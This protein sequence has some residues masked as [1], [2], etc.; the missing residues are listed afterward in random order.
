[1]IRY[2]VIVRWAAAWFRDGRAEGNAVL[3]ST[4]SSSR[5]KIYRATHRLPNKLVFNRTRYNVAGSTSTSC[6]FMNASVRAGYVL[7]SR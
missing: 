3:L 2:V 7:T 4:E 5:R 1:M 6:P